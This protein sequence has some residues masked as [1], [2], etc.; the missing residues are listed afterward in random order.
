MAHMTLEVDA[1]GDAAAQVRRCLHEVREGIDAHV[2]DDLL[3]LSSELVS[4]AARHA[5]LSDADRIRYELRAN[6]DNVRVDVIDPGR[7]FADDPLDGNGTRGWG[8]RLVQ[9]LSRRWGVRRIG[10]VTDVWFELPLSN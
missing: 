5:G 7:G 1:R 6:T 2:F 4:N 3:L 10:G 9:L 8:L